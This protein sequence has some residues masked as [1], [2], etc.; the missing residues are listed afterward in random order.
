MKIALLGVAFLVVLLAVARIFRFEY[1]PPIEYKDIAT[2]ENPLGRS[3][4]V[5]VADR[6]SNEVSC[7]SVIVDAKR[8]VKEMDQWLK[9]HRQPK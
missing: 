9:D 3:I 5:C 4:V 1:L 8:N 6:W 2:P 7:E